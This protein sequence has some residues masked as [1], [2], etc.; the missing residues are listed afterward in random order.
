MNTSLAFLVLLG[1]QGGVFRLIFFRNPPYF[2]GY[3]VFCVKFWSGFDGHD[4]EWA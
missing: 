3:A 4:N 2:I 1:F